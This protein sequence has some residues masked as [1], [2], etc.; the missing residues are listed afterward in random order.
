MIYYGKH[1]GVEGSGT[2]LLEYCAQCNI[3]SFAVGSNL[4]EHFQLFQTAG[5]FK[6]EAATGV[7]IAAYFYLWYLLCCMCFPAVFAEEVISLTLTWFGEKVCI[8]DFHFNFALVF[9]EQKNETVSSL[10]DV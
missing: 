9:K 10:E 5:Q 2:H 3:L 4:K 7:I 1:I 8:L 6:K